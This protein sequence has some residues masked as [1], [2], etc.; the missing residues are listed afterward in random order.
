MSK[1]WFKSWKNRSNYVLY[2]IIIGKVTFMIKI[3]NLRTVRIKYRHLDGP[4][5]Q[6]IQFLSPGVNNHL[7]ESIRSKVKPQNGQLLPLNFVSSNI[8]F[9]LVIE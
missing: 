3:R 9:I 8:G 1:I 6:L 2:L 5:L 7:T 4:E